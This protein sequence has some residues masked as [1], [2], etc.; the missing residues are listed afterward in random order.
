MDRRLL[1]ELAWPEPVLGEP[2]ESIAGDEL[3]DGAYVPTTAAEVEATAEAIERLRWH[4]QRLGVGIV[5][6]LH[7]RA[8]IAVSGCLLLL[9]GACTAM[10]C[11]DQT[12]LLAYLWSF[13]A[14]I[15][16]LIVINTG[17]NLATRI[18]MRAEVGL[19]VLWLGVVLL[20]AGVWGAYARLG[21]P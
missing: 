19:T 11:R 13:L 18:G 21:R 6:Q 4:I 7:M 15:L 16:M 10:L 1:P 8:A 9:L 17:E 3:L 2:I 5:S 14:A 20:G 12:P